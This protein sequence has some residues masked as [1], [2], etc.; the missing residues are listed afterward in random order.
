M[1]ETPAGAYAK[2][3]RAWRKRGH[4]IIEA[5]EAQDRSFGDIGKALGISRQRATQLYHLAKAR[6]AKG[7]KG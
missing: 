5:W 7:I 1:S 3:I 6:E 2:K 4:E